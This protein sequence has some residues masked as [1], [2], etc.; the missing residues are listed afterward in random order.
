MPKLL[1]PETEKNVQTWLTGDY[2][3]ETKAAIE[4][5]SP[6][7]LTDAF[8]QRLEFGTGGLRGIMGVGSNRMNVYNVRAATQGLANYI[9]KVRQGEPS[10]LISYDSR[11]QSRTF[12]E[13][14][15]RVLAAN[16]IHAY[17][18]KTIHPTPLASFGCRHLRCAAAV[19]VTASHNPPEYNG[20]KVYWHHGGQVLPPHDAGIIAEVD[21]IVSP[22]QVREA[23]LDDPMIEWVGEEIDRAYLEATEPLAKLPEQNH[24]HGGKLKVVYTSLHGTGEPL[25][26]ASMRQ[27]GFTD[28]Y[29]VEKQ[30][31]PDGDFPTLKKPNPEEHAAMQMGMDQVQALQADIL[32]GTDP[33]AD[34]LGVGV[35]HNGE[36]TLLNGNQIACLCLD[37]LLTHGDLPVFPAAIKTIVT[38]ELFAA[39][40]K[41][42]DVAC[43]NVLTGFKYIGQLMESWARDGDHSFVFGAEESYGYLTGT[44]ARDKD[45][46]APSSLVCEIALDAKLK[47]Q[48]LL[49]RLDALY[50]KYGLYREGLVSLTFTG[51]EGAD[52]MQQLMAALRAEHPTQ[53]AGVAVLSVEDYKTSTATDLKTGQQRPLT[54]PRSN[55]LLYWLDDGS[56]LVIRP[57]GTEPKIKLYG[58]VVERNPSS[59][60]TAD[61]RLDALLNALKQHLQ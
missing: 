28:L 10:V 17:I 4:K 33:D 48:T 56:R 42:H 14:T 35:R 11:H 24:A 20:Y 54:L 36:V 15:A 27:W 30:C 16:G 46:I 26:L 39:I 1:D 29:P 25:A 53:F 43:F 21:K 52:R 8:Y 34:R 61:R 41:A 55:V 3:A 60:E 45:A 9:L 40:C 51:K 38:T 2:D 5:M 59:I 12:A 18:F 32:L 47:G 44:H 37:H 49:D 50:T 19:M 23:P 6:E 57:S 58:G 31:I 22:D 13:E 7:E